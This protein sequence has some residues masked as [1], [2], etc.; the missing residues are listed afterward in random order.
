MWGATLQLLIRDRSW[1]VSIHAPVWGATADNVRVCPAHRFQST[2]PCGARR[3]ETQ[4]IGASTGFNPRA[5]VGRDDPPGRYAG[6]RKVSIHAPVWGATSVPAGKASESICFNP[7]ARVGRDPVETLVPASGEYVSIHAPVWGAT[8]LLVR[9]LRG[10]LFQSTR[11]CGARRIIGQ[12]VRTIPRFNPRARVGRD[13][14]RT[15]RIHP[16][17]GFNPRARVGRDALTE[18]RRRSSCPFQSTRPCGARQDDRNTTGRQRLFQS[19]RP[20]GARRFYYNSLCILFLGGDERGG[21]QSGVL[22]AWTAAHH[23]YNPL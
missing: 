4:S 23:G 21:S 5:R 12:M 8:F 20:C 16:S 9:W 7:R 6:K 13:C 19:T 11:P 2:R 1:S 22:F 3:T 10:L 14:A 18:V 15:D 17:A